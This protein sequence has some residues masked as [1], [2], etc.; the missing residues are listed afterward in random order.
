MNYLLRYF[1][2]GEDWFRTKYC[3]VPD[4]P[5][6]PLGPS[7]GPVGLAGFGLSSILNTTFG[8]DC[9]GRAQGNPFYGCQVAK[10]FTF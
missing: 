6:G 1:I 3:H 8:R 7:L 10:I 9:A 2:F 5:L 4:F